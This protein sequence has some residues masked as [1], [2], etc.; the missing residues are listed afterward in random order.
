MNITRT[1]TSE[2]MNITNPTNFLIALN[3]GTNGV[4]AIS[5][6]FTVWIVMIFVLL[7]N[8]YNIKRSFSASSYVGLVM[9]WLFWIVDLISP[10]WLYFF[11]IVAAT[12][13]ISMWVRRD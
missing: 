7:N 13:I 10:K 1:Y 3:N 12:G 8:G 4:L 11:L 6:L 5:A 9:A 2:M